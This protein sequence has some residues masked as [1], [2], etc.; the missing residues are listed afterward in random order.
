MSEHIYDLDCKGYKII[1]DKLGYAF[2][3]DS[4]LLANFAKLKRSDE[5]VEL[6]SGSGV[7]S[8]LAYA[9]CE[10]KSIV[11]VEIE[12]RLCDMANKTSELNKLCH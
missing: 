12:K 2:T 6:C 5:V 10:P 3:S 1:Q 11:G 8:V 9:K 7:I 4:V